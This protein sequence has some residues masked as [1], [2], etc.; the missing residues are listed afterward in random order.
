[1]TT[2]ADKWDEGT[3]LKEGWHQVKVVSFKI[4]R[5]GDKDIVKFVVAETQT[6]AQGKADFF[7][8][9]AALWRLVGFAKAC[10]L[11][12]EEARAYDPF[13]FRSHNALINRRLNV[14]VV[15]EEKEGKTYHRVEGWAP[16][17][18]EPDAPASPRLNRPNA[19]SDAIDALP[20]PNQTAQR[21]GAATPASDSVPF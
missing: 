14:E 1:M 11:T 18:E 12:R 15:P 19:I 21:G 13:N 5:P 4:E 6:G 20:P 3:W 9:D 8:T 16:L 2:L 7:L 17:S 10:G